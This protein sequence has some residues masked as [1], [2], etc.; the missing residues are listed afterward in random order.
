MAHEHGHHG[1]ARTF[2]GLDD[3]TAAFARHWDDLLDWVVEQAGAPSFVVDLGAGNGVASLGLA[4]RLPTA[5]ITAIDA[6]DTWFSVLA[7][8]AERAGVAALVHTVVADIDHE[9]PM[10]SADVVFASN[11]LHHVA[12]AGA[13]LRRLGDA[14]DGDAMLCVVEV[15]LPL[16]VL[17]DDDPAAAAER[18]AAD[19]L[20]MR[21]RESM[22][23]HGGPWA[24][25]IGDNG[26]QVVEEREFVTT[27]DPAS[28]AAAARHAL[29]HLDRLAAASTD[30]VTRVDSE[31]LL[32]AVD[33]AR[34]ATRAVSWDLR[35]SRTAVLAR[36]ART[37]DTR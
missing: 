17:A 2:D 8:R 37:A 23:L 29:R 15:A 30:R 13:V 27:A 4:R 9:V 7:E 21:L 12:D 22:P 19:A 25:V 32:D 20:G 6:Q 26:W 5:Q 18:R 33:R 24:Q 10:S 35:G 3:E 14:S 31:S 16:L 11:C 36:P 34:R 28:D 1:H